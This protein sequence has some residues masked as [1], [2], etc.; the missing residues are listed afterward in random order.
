MQAHGLADEPIFDVEK[1]NKNKKV[2]GL[3]L[4]FSFL[5]SIIFNVSLKLEYIMVYV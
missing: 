4:N 5:F 3:L 2:Y 1:E